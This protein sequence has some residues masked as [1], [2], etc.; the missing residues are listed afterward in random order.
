MFSE[1]FLPTNSSIQTNTKPIAN[2]LS[3]ITEYLC[4]K[5]DPYYKWLK[6][7]I[8][9]LHPLC[10]LRPNHFFLS[11]ENFLNLSNVWKNRY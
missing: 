5:V 8:L 11:L 2:N 3:K 9:I 6:T 10:Y 7:G 4:K 1:E